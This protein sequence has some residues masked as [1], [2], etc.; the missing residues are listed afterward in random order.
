M[1]KQE[2][3]EFNELQWEKFV[4]EALSALGLKERSIG[5]SPYSA[6]WKL[7]IASQLKRS[8]SVSNAWLS[9]RLNMG[10]PNAVSNN[11]GRYQR[12]CESDCEF[13]GR[14]KNMKYEH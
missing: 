9:H 8:S 10:A 3:K 6:R 5:D 11:C 13:A 7:A 1:E 14:L 2:L 12:E 4:Q